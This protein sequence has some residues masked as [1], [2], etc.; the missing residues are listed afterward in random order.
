MTPLIPS[1]PQLL[2][3]G[4]KY[5]CRVQL[6][7]ELM[8]V[9]EILYTDAL[10]LCVPPLSSHPLL[11]KAIINTIPPLHPLLSSDK[12]AG[13]VVT[14]DSTSPLGLPPPPQVI[15]EVINTST[16]CMTESRCTFYLFYIPA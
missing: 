11:I 12:I 1:P 2:M 4:N 14:I 15:E 7:L 3:C 16:G 8:H 5:P 10:I 13:A 6:G 9:H